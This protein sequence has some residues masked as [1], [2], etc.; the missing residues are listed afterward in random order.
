[1][2]ANDGSGDFRI[3]SGCPCKDAGYAS[4]LGLPS[5][6][7]RGKIRIYNAVVDMGCYEW[8]PGDP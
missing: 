3:K 8:N 5:T 4:V 7:L 2:F 6:D 1:M